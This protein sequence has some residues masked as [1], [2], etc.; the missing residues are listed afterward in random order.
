VPLPDRLKF[1]RVQRHRV[2]P[3]GTFYRDALDS[4]LSR[5]TLP[6]M[7]V[8][9]YTIGSSRACHGWSR[10]PSSDRNATAARALSIGAYLARLLLAARLAFVL[11]RLTASP[12]AAA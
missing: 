1:L 7:R 9:P 12:T 4:A 10:I 8:D 3:S 11:R 2:L 5:A 6:A